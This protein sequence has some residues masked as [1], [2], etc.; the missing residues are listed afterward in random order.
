MKL[1]LL[2]TLAILFSLTEAAPV[3]KLQGNPSIYC[4]DSIGNTYVANVD[5]AVNTK[6]ITDAIITTNSTL[7]MTPLARR[8]LRANGEDGREL[9][10][11]TNNGCPPGNKIQYCWIIGCYRRRQLQASA[12]A[13]LAKCPGLIDKAYAALANESAA[14]LASTG[15]YGANCSALI[16]SITVGCQE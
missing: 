1:Y 14:Q 10:W 13:T 2:T 7:Y 8:Q 3:L 16:S 11:C 12:G 9:T 15:P 4:P 6:A 5:G